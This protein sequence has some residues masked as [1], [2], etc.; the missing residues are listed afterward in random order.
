MPVFACLNANL[1]ISI[2]KR[3][4]CST[5]H[6]KGFP[7]FW[8]LHIAAFIFFMPALFVT[9]PLHLIYGKRK[10]AK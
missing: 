5:S 7:M 4:L 2:A 9:I 1:P 10:V 3:K 8:L 6:P